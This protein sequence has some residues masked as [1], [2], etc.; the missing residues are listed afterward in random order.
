[1][2]V[3]LATCWRT[4]ESEDPIGVYDNI[5]AAKAAALADHTRGGYEVIPLEWEPWGDKR[6]N[7]PA[8]KFNNTYY[9]VY[10][11]TLNEAWEE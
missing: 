8:D 6:I 10:I 7:A 3:Y 4:Y 11:M 5:E 2:I 9:V 1:M